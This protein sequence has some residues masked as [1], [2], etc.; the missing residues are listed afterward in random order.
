[1]IIVRFSQRFRI[2]VEKYHSV[3]GFINNIVNVPIYN[4]RFNYYNRPHN[5]TTEFEY[6][7]Y[8]SGLIMTDE[9]TV[10]DCPY[11]DRKYEVVSP[12]TNITIFKE[13]VE[14]VHPPFVLGRDR[15]SR[16]YPTLTEKIKKSQTNT[17]WDE[18]LDNLFD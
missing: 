18:E 9:L 4:P 12:Y 10:I 13:H 8:P 5:D 14:Q 7:A 17:L 1:M 15:D 3:H 16:Q 11:D 6:A 2:Y